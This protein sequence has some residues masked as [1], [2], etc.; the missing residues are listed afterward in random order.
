[1]GVPAVGRDAR[2]YACPPLKGAHKRHQ[3]LF[4][5]LSEPKLHGQVEEFNGVL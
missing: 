1:M 3:I 2:F 4:L 5:L